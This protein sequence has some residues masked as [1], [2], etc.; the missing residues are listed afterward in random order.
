MNKELV[1]NLKQL[2]RCLV[3]KEMTGED[4]EEKQEMIQKIEELTT[5]LNDATGRGIEFEEQN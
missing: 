5:Y 3:N 2:K 1:Q 4:W